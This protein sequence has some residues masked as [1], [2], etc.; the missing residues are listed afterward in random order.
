[1]AYIGTLCASQNQVFYRAS[2]NEYFVDD[3][4]TA[5][6]VAHEI[7][8]YYILYLRSIFDRNNPSLKEIPHKIKD[9]VILIL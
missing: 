4:T 3:I 9:V 7:G 1:M 6:I 5:E 2:I 8:K